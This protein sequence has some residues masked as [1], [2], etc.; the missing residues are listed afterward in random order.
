ME[1]EKENNKK[2]KILLSST[3]TEHAQARTKRMPQNQKKKRN[4]A[5]K[6]CMHAAYPKFS[7]PNRRTINLPLPHLTH[8]SSIQTKSIIIKTHLH[9]SIHPSIPI[10]K[11]PMPIQPSQN[12]SSPK[13]TKLSFPQKKKKFNDSPS[14]STSPSPPPAAAAGSAYNQGT[15]PA[16]RD[17]P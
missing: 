14:S 3:I 13:K 12:P 1:D 2:E 4:S 7:F 9:P 5:I 6:S 16:P 17:S 10:H 11:L 15:A 8:P